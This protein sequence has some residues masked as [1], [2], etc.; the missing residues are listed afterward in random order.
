MNLLQKSVIFSLQNSTTFPDRRDS[1]PHYPAVVKNSDCVDVY[2]FKIALRSR[3]GI[4]RE[5]LNL[6]GDAERIC[7][8]REENV[9]ETNWSPPF[10]TTSQP[11][12]LRLLEVYGKHQKKKPEVPDI[13]VSDVFSLFLQ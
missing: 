4:V 13:K 10:S 1:F 9:V 6:G 11:P 7:C 5:R 3:Q 8:G 2:I 12:L